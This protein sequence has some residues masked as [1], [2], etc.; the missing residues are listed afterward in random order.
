MEIN[1]EGNQPYEMM[2]LTYALVLA[3]KGDK[4]TAVKSMEE[5]KKVFKEKQKFRDKLINNK[6]NG[7]HRTS[8]NSPSNDSETH[9]DNNSNGSSSS[10][11]LESHPKTVNVD[12]TPDPI[13]THR[14]PIRPSHLHERS[15][16]MERFLPKSHPPMISNETSPLFS[17]QIP[18]PLFHPFLYPFSEIHRT[19]NNLYH[20]HFPIN[21]PPPSGPT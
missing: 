15:F 2:P 16:L 13:E 11:A 6:E 8:D 4:A 1:R 17:Y 9:D 5:G 20:P 14:E 10:P 18:N 3:S 7:N 19:I 21:F 12:R